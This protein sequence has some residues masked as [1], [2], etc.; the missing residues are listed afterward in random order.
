[1]YP[2][3][4]KPSMSLANDNLPKL[5]AEYHENSQGLSI[6]QEKNGFV[7]KKQFVNIDKSQ[8]CVYASAQLT[9]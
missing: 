6:K 7:E 8:N 4:S 3:Q 9:E 1:M 2:S 5:V